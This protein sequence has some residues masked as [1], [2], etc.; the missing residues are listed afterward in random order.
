[1]RL[2]WTV[3]TLLY[4]P[5]YTPPTPLW[6]LDPP[7][8]SKAKLTAE[9]LIEYQSQF[10]ARV[11]QNKID[12]GEAATIT[13]ALSLQGKRANRAAAQRIIDNGEAATIEEAYHIR[14]RRAR[15]ASWQKVI[16]RGLASTLEEAGR[17]RAA[18]LKKRYEEKYTEAE[19]RENSRKAALAAAQKLVDS[20]EA[21]TIEEAY[22]VRGARAHQANIEKNG[23]DGVRQMCVERGQKTA[24]KRGQ[25]SVYPG[26]RWQKKQD[27]K[28]GR[29][30]N[31]DRKKKNK[32]RKKK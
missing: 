27:R 9:E 31:K 17:W 12:S 23:V 7:C 30:S 13:E 3:S 16:D 6:R 19:R 8:M 25:R 21:A 29:G 22:K 1:M 2:V 20:G 24:W 10:A 15:E 4:T 11:A 28:M 14:A 26:V 18:Q 5:L 32:E